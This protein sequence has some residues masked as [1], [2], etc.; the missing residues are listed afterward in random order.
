MGQTTT[1]INVLTASLAL[2]REMDEEGLLTLQDAIKDRLQSLQRGNVSLQT[3][4]SLHY[5]ISLA[6][7]SAL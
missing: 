5:I 2:I 1:S 7:H 3:V 4:I 6:R